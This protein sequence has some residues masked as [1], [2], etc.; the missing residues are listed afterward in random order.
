[1]SGECKRARWPTL[2]F[3]PLHHTLT[4]VVQ[5]VEALSASESY[6]DAGLPPLLSVE[7][8]EALSDSL[9]DL[10]VWLRSP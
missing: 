5:V 1:V 8:E 9:E 10:Q 2:V 7:S 4:L 6:V 3:A